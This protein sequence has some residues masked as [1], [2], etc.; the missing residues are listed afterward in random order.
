MNPFT[1]GMH[2]LDQ[3]EDILQA[4]GASD[5]IM[6]L[7]Y[8]KDEI[9]FELYQTAW[10]NAT[11]LANTTGLLGDL[12]ILADYLSP[13]DRILLPDGYDDVDVNTVD[14]FGMFVP[15]EDRYVNVTTLSPNATIVWS[16]VTG[17]M[18]GKRNRRAIE[19][20][21]LSTSTVAVDG[22]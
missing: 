8:A 5:A 13:T 18:T 19:M 16:N 10:D 14:K 4:S 22:V 20:F 1:G 15:S 17:V 2:S 9:L 11:A 21:S 3:Y 6:P 7:V 12:T